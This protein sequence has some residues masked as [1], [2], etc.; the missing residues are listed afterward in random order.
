MRD[1]W[2]HGAGGVRDLAY[3]LSGSSDLY[4]DDGRSPF[5]SINF[6]TA[7][8]G[9]TMRDLVS[10]EHKHNEAN[11]E[12]NRDGTDD[13]RSY[14]C[15]VEG[16][17][18]DV[19]DHHAARAAG[20]QPADHAGALDRRA[21]AGRRRRALAHA[22]RQQQ[23]LLPGQRDLL[24]RL[25]RRPP[26]P[27][28]AARADP[29]PDRAAPPLAGAAPARV[30]RGTAGAPGGDGCKDLA[31]FHPDG[32]EMADADWFD[33]GLRTHRHVPGRA[34]ACATATGAAR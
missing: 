24:A 6:V 16:E 26:R 7:H 2:S 13:N 19:A 22:G 31:W 5:A 29:Q 33:A 1:F 18:D 11:G 30:L 21:D 25:D 28:D 12:D 8:D 15:G 3:R 27:T 14:N 4:A 20:A 10:Y 17:T 34:R 9:F 23:R 32:R